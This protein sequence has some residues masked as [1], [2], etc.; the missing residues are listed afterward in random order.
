M[1]EP[2]AALSI[3]MDDLWSYYKTAG[4]SR[5]QS[6]PSFLH[7]AMPRLFQMLDQHAFGLTAFVIGQDVRRA[8]V[9][10]WLAEMVRRGCELGNHSDAHD[11]AIAGMSREEI[12]QQL[13]HVEQAV[14]DEFDVTLKGYRGP[15]FSYSK[16]LLEVLAERGYTYD[17][18]TFPTFLGPLAR[19]YHR[20]A[21]KGGDEQVGSDQLFGSWREGFC[22]LRPFAWRLDAG[23]LIEVPTG[24][25]PIFRLPV[26]GTY[27]H[28]LADISEPLALLYF[29]IYLGLCRLTHT[30]PVF[31]L[32]AS[33]FIGADDLDDSSVIPGM[34]RSGAEKVAFMKRIFA[35]LGRR[36]QVVGMHEFCNRQPQSKTLKTPPQAQG[37]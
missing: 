9:R 26:H 6:Y 30:L 14:S 15:S 16:N 18:S 35:M 37:K 25:M 32:H 34:R 12:A 29:R 22:S 36:Y 8:T 19:W 33:D 21:A 2:L 24:T 13:T 3:D 27:L 5:W 20:I 4:D 28:F 1:S 17:C 31:L 23:R 10:P 11:A 7:V